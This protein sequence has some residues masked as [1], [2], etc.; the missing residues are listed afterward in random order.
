MAWG[1]QW[2]VKFAAEKTQAVVISRS[3]EDIRLIE[4]QLKFGEDTLAIK[5]S[6]NILGL[7]VDSKLS[8]DFQLENEAPT[9]CQGPHDI[10]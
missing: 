6:I 1:K 10:V 9:R 2:Q 3:R 5:E 4:G 7:E 8:F